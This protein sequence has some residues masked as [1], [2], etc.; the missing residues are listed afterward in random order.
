[1]RSKSLASKALTRSYGAERT[2]IGLIGVLAFLGGLAV[3]LVGYRVF[4]QYRGQRSLLDPLAVSWVHDHLTFTRV[5]AIVLGVLLFIV[6]LW[7]F[8]RSLRTEKH[9][10]LRLDR[11]HGHQLTVTHGAITT[12]IRTD[13]EAIPAVAKA[14]VRSVGDSTNPVLRLYLSLREGSDLKQAWEEVNRAL[15]RARTSLGIPEL[16]IAVCLEVETKARQRVH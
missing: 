7:W 2:L 12:A 16:P 15:E 4:G 1:M 13:L 11:A 6:G 5:A 8:R 10:N 14:R 9:P 3:L